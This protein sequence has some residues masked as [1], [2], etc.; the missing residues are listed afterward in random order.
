MFRLLDVARWRGWRTAALVLLCTAI[1]FVQA[2]IADRQGGVTTAADAD[3]VM[4]PVIMYH[5]VSEKSDSWGDYVISPAEFEAD[6]LYLQEQG[7]TTVTVAD[8]IAYVDK[9][10]ALPSRPVMLT[11]DDGYYNNYLYAYPL[12]KQYEMRAVISPISRWTDFYSDNERE[13]NHAA[14]SHITWDQ[15]REMAADGTVEFQCH[16]YDMHYSDKMHRKGVT[17]RDG[18]SAEQ[19]RAVLTEDITR[20]VRAM[21]EEL[22]VMPTTFTYPFGAISRMTDEVL[23][24]LGFRATLGCESRMNHITRDATCL[25]RLG[26]Y[27]RPHKKSV[28]ELLK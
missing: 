17:R 18:E 21:T 8:L 5:S 25:Y 7:Y 3:E 2:L 24:E 27:L 26:R 9:G 28:Q 1:A 11:F 15:M 16:S 14:Y 4:L 22:G 13:Q 6:L 20:A 19:Y 23:R 12:L 10:V